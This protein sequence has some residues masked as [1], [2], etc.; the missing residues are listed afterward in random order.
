ML[1]QARK[2]QEALRTRERRD[3]EELACIQE[4]PENDEDLAREA[5]ED[6]RKYREE[7]RRDPV[8]RLLMDYGLFEF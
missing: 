1:Q 2:E 6:D 4:E 5:E 3:D 7:M 8:M